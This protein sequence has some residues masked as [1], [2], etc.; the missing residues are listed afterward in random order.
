M[1]AIYSILM[2]K[3]G[4]SYTMIQLTRKVFVYGFVVITLTLLANGQPPVP[5][6]LDG[7]GALS[8][9]YLGIAASSLGFILWNQAIKAIGSVKTSQYIYLIPVM[10]T[11]MS[12]VVLRERITIMTVIGTILILSG[13]YLSEKAQTA[14]E[15]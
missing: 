11:A 13:L 3:T 14:Q 9:I 12:A 5:A 10:T 7:N 8:L 1:F 6:D 2:Q 15:I 4:S